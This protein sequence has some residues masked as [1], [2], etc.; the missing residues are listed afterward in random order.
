MELFSSYPQAF[1]ACVNTGTFA[2]ARLS[3]L[4]KRLSI[5]STGCHKVF[6]TLSGDKLFHLN[7][8]ICQVQPGHLFLVHA[9]TWHFFS[10]YDET[11]THPRYVLFIHPDY[12]RRSSTAQTD[13]SACF[14]HSRGLLL[15][16]QERNRLLQLLDRL[17]GSEE[18]GSDLLDHSAFLQ[19]MVFLNRLSMAGSPSPAWIPDKTV[20]DLQTYLT[21]HITEPLTIAQLAA[22]CFLSPSHLCKTFRAATG[23]TIH[24]YILAQRIARA[25]ELLSFGYPILDV[26][27]MCGFREY[28]T[29]LRAFR[30]EVGMTPSRYA[31]FSNA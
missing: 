10:H 24:Q 18:Y 19:I 11:Q 2:V 29:F 21:A 28:Q 3:H 23:T 14:S 31:R 9:D 5:D 27:A 7:D 17:A 8:Q 20:H 13:L 15:S 22:H 26:S 1:Q 4:D 16:E 6:L 30:R 12:L 25:K